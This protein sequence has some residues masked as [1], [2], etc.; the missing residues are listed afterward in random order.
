MQLFSWLHK[1]MTGRPYTRP[2]PARKPTPRFRP[3]LEVLEG[4]DLPSFASPVAIGSYYMATLVT[5]DANGDGKPDLLTSPSAGGAGT[6]WLNNGNGTFVQGRGLFDWDTPTA[7][8]VG[9]VNGDGKLDFVF[10]NQPS[11]YPTAG[12]SYVT[13]TVGLGDGG[14]FTPAIAPFGLEAILPGSVA[15][16]TL[17]DVYGNGK[18]DLVGVGMDGRVYVAQ[19]LGGGLFSTA[20][21]YSTPGNLANRVAVQ[22][23]VGDL[24]GDGKPD[25][26]VTSPMVNSVSVLMNNGN[27]T[28]APAQTYSVGGTPTAVAVG[29]FNRGGKLDIVTA[30][31][32]GTVSVL[33]NNGNGAFGT[34]QNY[35]I[36]GPA[37]SVAVGDFNHDGFLDVATTGS[38]E[39]D[40]LLNNG[41]GTFGPYQNVGPAGSSVVAADFKPDGYPDLAELVG[42]GLIKSIDVL[43]NKADWMPGPVALSFGAITYKSQTNVFSETV[44][45]TNNTSG[46]LT[47]PLSLELTNLPSG[48]VL[49]D[50][51]GTTNGNPYIRFLKSGKTITKGASVSITLTFTAA[52]LSDITFGTEVVPL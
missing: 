22:V 18:L 8:A 47:G 14:G 23:T 40:V 50:A 12:P 29:D 46:T 36:G 35:A 19:N 25:I 43:I 2:T 27:G 26:I 13:V 28:F 52:S 38:T 9:D 4:R 37:N 49:T 32:N 34:A 16:L 48:V 20:K 11:N 5:A 3:Q 45:L 39:M 30:N 1:W 42:T 44:T 7:M 6:Q 33:L 24:N 21:S 41:N 51:T 31:A 10:A 17:A 15:S